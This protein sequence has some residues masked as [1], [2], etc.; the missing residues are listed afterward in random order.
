[1]YSNSTVIA[2]NPEEKPSI[3]DFI[4]QSKEIMDILVLQNKEL[5]RLNK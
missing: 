3:M 2:E 5:T 1:L 4:T